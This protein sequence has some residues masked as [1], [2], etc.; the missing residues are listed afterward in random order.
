M[1]GP[2]LLSASR[3][4]MSL[5]RQGLRSAP[6]P[7][8]PG[9]FIPSQGDDGGPD[10]WAFSQGNGCALGLPRGSSLLPYQHSSVHKHISEEQKTWLGGNVDVSEEP[11]PDCVARRALP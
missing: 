8:H 4:S 7:G 3:P 2:F 1:L 5:S 11:W 9:V 10:P 6:I